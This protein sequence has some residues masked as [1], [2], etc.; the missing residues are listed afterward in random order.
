MST[1]VDTQTER[2]FCL[3]SAIRADPDNEVARRGL[4]LLG[5]RPAG[6]DVRP[7]PPYHPRWEKELDKE[8]GTTQKHLS[9][10]LGKSNPAI[11]C[12][13]WGFSAN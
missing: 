4:I 5:A 1:L 9:T 8:L 7:V 10:H 2:I 12:V 13:S 3:E 11:I 6:P